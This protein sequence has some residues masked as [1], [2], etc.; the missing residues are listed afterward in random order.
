MARP[1]SAEQK[2]LLGFKDVALEDKVS[3]WDVSKIGGLPDLP[4][5][6]TLN[7]PTCPLC[8]SVLLHIVQVY[9]PLENS[10]FHRIIYVFACSKKPCWGKPESWVALRSQSLEGHKLDVPEPSSFQENKMAAADWC[11]DADDWGMDD[12]NDAFLS[13]PAPSQAEICPAGAPHTDWTSQMKNLTLADTQKSA[14]S[15]EVFHSY[16]IAVAE[17]EECQWD[18][19][20][21]HARQ[22]LR[23]Y[24]QRESSVADVESSD[25]KGEGEKYEKRKQERQDL[26]FS[27]FLKKISLCRQQILRYSWNG[28]PLYMSPLNAVSQPPPC[29]RCG[30]KRVFEFQLMP[31][32]VT[33]LRGTSNDLL[34]EFGTVL[35]F[36]CERSCWGATD[37]TLTEECCI[38]QE[39]PDQKYFSLLEPGTTMSDQWECM[40]QEVLAQVFYYLPL[41]DRQ[42]VS[43]VCQSWASAVASNAVWHYTEICWASEDEL[44][45]LDGLQDLVIQIKHLKIVF[46]QSKEANRKNVV[47]FLECLAKKSSRLQSLTLTC[48]G[49]NPLFYSGL[50]ILDSIMELCRKENI[51]LQHIDIRGLPFTLSDGFIRL[52]ATGSPN[53]CSFYINSRTL[54]CHVTPDS[55]IDVLRKCPKLSSLGTFGSSLS[56]DV[57]QELLKKERP[58]FL[59]LDILCKRLD[60]YSLPIS[61]EAWRALCQRHPSLSVDLEF[62]HTVLAWKIPRILKPNIPIATLQFNTYTEL[63][64]HLVFV[65]NHYMRT[66]R[67]LVIQTTT[68]GDLNSALIELAKVCFQLEEI[69]CY[70]LVSSDVIK[71]FLLNCPRLKKYTLKVDKEKY[72]W[73]ATCC[74][75]PSLET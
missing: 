30:G 46:D 39:D 63:T 60:K 16:Y 48:C 24:E 69:H 3:S 10:L 37:H 35:I 23:E 38:V 9:C 61:D 73:R 33:M 13:P 29:P 7:F 44:V 41:S 36:T 71:A 50:E 4:P 72:P 64:R 57:F 28:D 49:E 45:S 18:A 47:Q 54:V 31:A 26:V 40:P 62:D 59:H 58:P 68:S 2:V 11:D 74:L 53:L 70:C 56:E 8:S 42:A 27:K 32:L 6:V 66:I 21:D 34:I 52:V 17:E 20:L 5:H 67:K 75:P 14:Q 12:N 55:L 25:G 22:L 19:D 1:S 65:S 15:D 51:D 43:Q